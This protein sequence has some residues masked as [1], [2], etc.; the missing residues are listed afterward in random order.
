M[1]N[2]NKD[3]IIKILRPQTFIIFVARLER[4]NSKMTFEAQKLSP[5]NV[6]EKSEKSDIWRFAIRISRLFW[7]F[8]LRF[9]YD[10][11]PNARWK[12]FLPFRDHK[13]YLCWE[14]RSRLFDLWF[15]FDAPVGEFR[16]ILNQFRVNTVISRFVSLF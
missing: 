13:L 9:N 16:S 6:R 15:S 3:I 10:Y 14:I 2:A 5:K 4:Y 12:D 7:H 11:K 8:L 1:N